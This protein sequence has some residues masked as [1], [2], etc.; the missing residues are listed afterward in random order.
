MKLF[1]PH[2]DQISFWVGFI[3]ANL[4]WLF[5]KLIRPIFE[6]IL[7]NFKE[8]RR[9]SKNRTVSLVEEHYLSNVYL[10]TQRLHLASSLFSLD[11]ILIIPKLLAPPPRISPDEPIFPND[12]VEDLV[13]YLPS[14][15][16]VGAT[17]KSPTLSIAQALS[18]NSDI[19]ITG[20]PG[21][22]KSVCLSYLA[23][24][25]AQHSGEPGF[26]KDLIPFLI[27]LEDLNL[28]SKITVD[29]LNPIIDIVS[30]FSPE[31]DLVRIPQFI[32]KT[33]NDGRALI[34]LD[35]TDEI[36][37]DSLDPT[38]E[39][40]RSIKQKY[41]LTRIITTGI[42]ENLAG[43]V[44]LNFIPF[45]LTCW[46]PSEISNFLTKWGDLWYLYLENDNIDQPQASNQIDHFLMNQWISSLNSNLSPFELTLLT[47]G[48]YAGDIKS[49]NILD[50]ISSHILRI[51]PEGASLESLEIL[52]LKA[53]ISANSTFDL[54]NARE[55][56]KEF[57]P[58]DNN[59]LGENSELTNNSNHSASEL[60]NN[61]RNELPAPS[62]GLIVKFIEAGLLSS[63]GNNRINFANQIFGGFLAGNVLGNTNADTI[64][65]L[66][67]WSGKYLSLNYFAALHDGSQFAS[68][69]INTP[70]NLLQRNILTVARW[71]RLASL[72]SE[73]KISLMENLVSLLRTPRQPLGLRGQV[74]AAMVRSGDEGVRILFRQ[75]LDTDD[76][77]LLQLCF[78]GSAML[79]DT[80]A[81][82]EIAKFLNHI[83]PNVHKTACLALV[84]IGTPSA[85]DHVANSL[86]HGEKEIRK[87]AAQALANNSSEG[88]AMLREGVNMEDFLVRWAV[89]YGLGR[90][91]E[92]WATELLS[93]VQIEDDQ[94]I[95]RNAATE[96]I[97]K[98]LHPDHH[99]PKRLPPP[100]ECP[101]LISF[102]AKRGFGISPN[103]PATEVLLLALTEGTEEEQL[104]SLDYLRISSSSDVFSTFYKLMVGNNMDLREAIFRS[105][106]EM[107]SRGVIIPDP[108]VFGAN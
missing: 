20:Q 31:N 67:N 94:W 34:L 66:P 88:H 36:T 58:V 33:F 103:T 9:T 79:K 82:N 25:I 84:T 104:A 6:Q 96:V 78:L 81:I 101:W 105:I 72:E 54:L 37:P 73:W 14:W 87:A 74:M 80:K 21:T 75:M 1:L 100:S 98:K 62:K 47:W 2:I 30:S 18:G 23:S 3:L 16:E 91:D 65:N 45:T 52:A 40:I 50:S 85:L 5:V 53:L 60:H 39:F 10:L 83:S 17:F 71:L 108:S 24:R 59:P 49:G 69:L 8:A 32:N 22:G 7:H 4:V 106:W 19:I 13:P 46:E 93:K 15:P 102:A 70:D 63:H 64:F 43:L 41:P 99:I 35:G 55:W 26:P 57:E 12:F 89:V 38:I 51:K 107:A 76:P 97:E 28:S 86:L 95:V 77:D 27:N 11:E 44:T 56:I 29:P 42:P 61:L 48:S 90:I 92:F 68:K